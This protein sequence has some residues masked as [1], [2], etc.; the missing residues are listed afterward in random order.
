MIRYQ[1][2]S[3]SPRQHTA[4]GVVARLFRAILFPSSVAGMLGWTSAAIAQPPGGTPQEHGSPT[5]QYVMA[6]FVVVAIMLILCMPTRK[7][8]ST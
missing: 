8:P 1:G 4:S 5:P 3:M 7:R 6:F 2:Q